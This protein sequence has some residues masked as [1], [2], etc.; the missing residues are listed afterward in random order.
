MIYLGTVNWKFQH[1]AA[2]GFYNNSIQDRWLN[3][4]SQK[5]SFVEIKSTISEEFAEPI[6]SKW[7]SDTPQDFIFSA[8]APREITYSD[9][10]TVNTI[11]IEK[12][13]EMMTPLN[14]KFGMVVL[15]F[16]KKM[17]LSNDTKNFVFEVLDTLRANFQGYFI[18]DM[19]NRSWMREE[20]YSELAPKETTMLSTDKRPVSILGDKSE[21]YYLKLSGDTRIIPKQEFGKTYF[22]REA[23]I[24]Q[25]ANHLKVK[26]KRYKRIYVAIGNHF[27]GNAVDDA[28]NL[29]KELKKY[30]KVEV[31]GFQDRN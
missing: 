19:G 29:A 3:V 10:L 21:I 22:P 14:S 9:D 27:S 28:Y 6:V 8:R 23:E 26:Y 5:S 11:A 30:N 16:P 13:L 20:F 1:W 2:S 18:L 24:K 7:Y 12:F 4:Y 25:W 15:Q 17:Q 31:N